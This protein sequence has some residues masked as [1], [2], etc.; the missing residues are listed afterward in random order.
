M[1]TLDKFCDELHAAAA[2][3]EAERL[4]EALRYLQTGTCD[5]AVEDYDAL[6]RIAA[7][8]EPLV[9]RIHEMMV[10]LAGNWRWR[11]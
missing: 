2:S 8:P 10:T 6:M 4:E 1:S 7:K 9:M 3:P 11:T 5:A